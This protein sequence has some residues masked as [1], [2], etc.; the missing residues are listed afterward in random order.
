MD[1]PRKRQRFSWF[2]K[3]YSDFSS[4]GQPLFFRWIKR[5][6]FCGK[7]YKKVKKSKIYMKKFVLKMN[8][9]TKIE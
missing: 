9:Y 2:V 3:D 5:W 1:N 4:G 7:V 8:N 6:K